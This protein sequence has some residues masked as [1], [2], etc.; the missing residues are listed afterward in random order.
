M[1]RIALSLALSGSLLVYCF[2]GP[3]LMAQ[4][5]EAAPTAAACPPT[6]TL[7][8]LIKAIDAGVSGPASKDRVC[9]RELLLPEARLA[10][11]AKAPDGSFVPH[12]LTFDEWSEGIRK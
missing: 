9:M 3:M 7:D 4:G 11:M 1:K 2:S 6:T 10:P 5:T 12:I 8:E